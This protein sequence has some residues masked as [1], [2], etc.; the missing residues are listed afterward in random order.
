MSVPV[1][2]FRTAD[3]YQKSP[4]IIYFWNFRD[5]T[6][7]WSYNVV[8][9]GADHYLGFQQVEVER[10][11]FSYEADGSQNANLW[12]R[13]DRPGLIFFAAMRAPF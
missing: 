1:E 11:T 8:P 4:E 10:T 13:V 7:F 12:V 3:V 2:V 5:D 9:S 6:H